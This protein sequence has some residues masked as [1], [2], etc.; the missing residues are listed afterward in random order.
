MTVKIE[1]HLLDW[2]LFLSIVQLVQSLIY[3]GLDFL[4]L[5]LVKFFEFLVSQRSLFGLLAFFYE[6]FFDIMNHN[7]D[8]RK[9]WLFSFVWVL[10]FFKKLSLIFQFFCQLE[11]VVFLC[12]LSWVL[13]QLF[14]WNIIFLF[15]WIVFS[16]F[17]RWRIVNVFQMFHI[18]GYSI[19][20]LILKFDKVL[21]GKDLLSNV[22]AFLFF[23]DVFEKWFIGDQTF[24]D[25]KYLFLKLLGNLILLKDD[26]RFCIFKFMFVVSP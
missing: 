22:L 16:I 6:F 14:R 10:Q 3:F 7:S 18:F 19:D 1:L 12:F 2:A 5:L 25:C 8:L 9:F 23:F 20:L 11:N 24:L 4:F 26:K 21:K 17:S 13:I 15:S